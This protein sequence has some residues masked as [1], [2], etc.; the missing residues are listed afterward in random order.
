MEFDII[1][2]H[3]DTNISR[4]KVVVSSKGKQTLKS[5]QILASA[6]L[7]QN[8]VNLLWQKLGERGTNK[9]KIMPAPALKMKGK[10]RPLTT[11]AAS[12]LYAQVLL[13]LDSVHSS[14]FAKQH[15]KWRGDYC[16][17]FFQGS[18]PLLVK[19]DYEVTKVSGKFSKV[20]L[21]YSEEFEKVISDNKKVLKID[22]LS[23][24]DAVV[25]VKYFNLFFHDNY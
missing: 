7:F 23:E 3:L 19:L 9:G 16:N 21:Q 10:R 18:N 2:T 22:P 11:V 13:F 17:S 25:E 5:G 1:C 12:R 4:A 20:H 6:I 8:D 24:D 14:E 15:F